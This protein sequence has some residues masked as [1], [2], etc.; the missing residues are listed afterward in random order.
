MGEPKLPS[1]VILIAAICYGDADDAESALSQ[2]IARYGTLQ[3]KSESFSFNHTQYY[4]HEMGENLKK[5]FCAFTNLIDPSDIVDI[6]LF[7]NEL[8]KCYTCDNKRK[9]N[10]DPGYLEAAKLVLATT[11]NYSHRI[12]LGKGIYGDVQLYWRHGRFCINEWTYPDYREP[13]AIAFFTQLRHH[14]LH[15]GELLWSLP[16]E[17]QA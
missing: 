5:F 17:H 14:L 9:V 6:K 3:M 16:T 2:M 8:E 4:R 15:R 7:T 11:K 1:P 10:I 13:L 12:Y